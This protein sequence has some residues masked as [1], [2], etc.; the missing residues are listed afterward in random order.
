MFFTCEVLGFLNDWTFFLSS[1]CVLLIARQF[2]I[3]LYELLH[4]CTRDFALCF[5][6]SLTVFTSELCCVNYW[7]F[8]PAI[9]IVLCELI[10]GHFYLIRMYSFICCFLKLEHIAHYKAKNQNTVKTTPPPH[11]HTHTHCN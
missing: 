7:T 5:A 3:V 2:C 6:N 1:I 10:T 8:L 9:C 11:T 4:I